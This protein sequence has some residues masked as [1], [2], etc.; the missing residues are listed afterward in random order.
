MRRSAFTLIE[1]LV[2]I[3]IIGILLALLLPAVQ[4]VRESARCTQCK[5]NLRQIGIAID[6]YHSTHGMFP[7]GGSRGYSLHVFLLPH[8]EQSG[9]AANVDFSIAQDAPQ[10]DSVRATCISIYGCP[11]DPSSGR[12]IATMA[13]TNYAGNSGTGV[14]R[15]GYNGLFRHLSPGFA[16]YPEGPVRAS[17][18]TDGLSNTAAASEIVIGNGNYSRLTTN[19]NTPS[20]MILPVELDSFAAFCRGFVPSGSAGDAWIRGRPWTFGDSGC[21]LYNHILTPNSNNC[22]NGTNVQFGAYSAASFHGN[23]V[24]LLYADGRVQFISTQ[25]SSQI[26]NA[27]GS[28]DGRE[29]YSSM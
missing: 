25:I 27:W 10:N 1:L 8:I 11:S 9:L 16:P 20:P 19:W 24:N 5:S 13:G 2:S 22:I 26:W 21:T 3:S 7:P 18:V 6:S 14:Q 4:Q 29:T 23:G 12:V 28:R 17:D 15:Y